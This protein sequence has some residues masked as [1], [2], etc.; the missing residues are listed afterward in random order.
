MFCNIISFY[1]D[2]YEVC[3]PKRFSQMH[4]NG[5]ALMWNSPLTGETQEVFYLFKICILQ[6]HI[7]IKSDIYV[8]CSQNISQRDIFFHSQCGADGEVGLLKE[9]TE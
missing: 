9:N 4:L 8:L 5:Y 2:I 6:P 1:S 3:A 7:L